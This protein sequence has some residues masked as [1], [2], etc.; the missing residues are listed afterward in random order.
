MSQIRQAIYGYVTYRGRRIL[1]LQD[2]S[3]PNKFQY[4]DWTDMRSQPVTRFL[5]YSNLKTISRR[6]YHELER[7]GVFYEV[8]DFLFYQMR[9]LHAFLKFIPPK[10]TRH[11]RSIQIEDRLDNRLIY[12]DWRS[13]SSEP[14]EDVVALLKGCTQLQRLTFDV[15]DIAD[16][17]LKEAKQ[18]DELAVFGSA[19]AREV[20]NLFKGTAQG[21]A[22]PEAPVSEL[23]WELRPLRIVMHVRYSVKATP[24]RHGPPGWEECVSDKVVIDL[25]DTSDLQW[26]RSTA[27]DEEADYFGRGCGPLKNKEFRDLIIETKVAV[28]DYRR[29]LP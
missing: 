13:G 29:G 20:L 28:A 17:R 9:Y 14:I 7:S 26:L 11:I 22:N 2:A 18:K 25:M 4:K 10:K 1:P 27:G 19:D 24:E 15:R 12:I 6:F 16:R 8:N 23:F 21:Q 5:D 3:N